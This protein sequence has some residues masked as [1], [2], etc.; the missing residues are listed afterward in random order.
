MFN[1]FNRAN[2]S[3]PDATIGAATAGTISSTLG[4]RSQQVALK[5][6]F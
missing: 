3:N 6:N 1:A 4:A 2:F 5:L